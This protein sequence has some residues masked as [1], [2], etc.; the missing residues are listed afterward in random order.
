MPLTQEQREARAGGIGGSDAGIIAGLAKWKTPVQLWQE[1]TGRVQPPNLDDNELIE[2]GNEFEAVIGRVWSRRTGNKIRRVNKT[3]YD[4]EHPWMLGHIDF[5]VVGKNEGLEC[6]QANWFMRD[7]WGDEDSDDVPLYYL[8]QGVHYM[9]IRDADAWNFAVLLGGNSLRKYHVERD[10]ESE[11][12]LIDLESK[13]WECVT[14]DV[15][16]PPIAVEDLAR[17]WPKTGGPIRAT[18][19]V[20]LAVEEFKA[21]RAEVKERTTR[22][23]ELKLGI[24]AYMG[25]HGILIDPLED[26]I[27][28]ATYKAHDEN[29]IDVNRLR[30]EQPAIAAE[31]TKTSAVRK[32]LPK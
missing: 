17:V 20:T 6:K 16:P 25:E 9:R 3:I 12:H 8:I 23:D 10:L 1:K 21:L 7:L 24:G 29:R 19:E 30:E 2:F 14:K 13:F 18:E 31:Y 27:T 11:K 22:M 5:D 32:F 26:S 28:I 4:S 15:A